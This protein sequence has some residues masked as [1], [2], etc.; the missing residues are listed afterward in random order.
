MPFRSEGGGRGLTINTTSSLHLP[1][2]IFISFYYKKEGY[3]P[4]FPP[5]IQKGAEFICKGAFYGGLFFKNGFSLIQ[6]DMIHLLLDKTGNPAC[7]DSS[8]TLLSS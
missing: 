3:P 2:Y 1:F 6:I 4:Y 8:M 7:K 5:K